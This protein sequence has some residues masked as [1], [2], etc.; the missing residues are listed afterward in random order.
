MYS[1]NEFSLLNFEPA[2]KTTQSWNFKN[3]YLS[4]PR[5]F[6][7]ST[8]LD[9]Q[10]RAVIKLKLDENTPPYYRIAR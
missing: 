6:N 5:A 7:Y 4:S 1:I 2:A 8:F 9:P 3:R 10:Q